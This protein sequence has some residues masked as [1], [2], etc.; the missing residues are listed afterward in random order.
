LHLAPL[1]LQLGD[2]LHGLLQC[3]GV[4]GLWGM[5]GSEGWHTGEE[6]SAPP[7]PDI[8]RQLTGLELLEIKLFRVSKP[9]LMLKRLFCSA[10]M[11]FI[12][13]FC[14]GINGSLGCWPSLGHLTLYHFTAR[15]MLSS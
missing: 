1:L 15:T 11:C 7:D 3:D 2:V 4:A 12:C 10:E 13:R 6:H 8:L 14:W 9:I 5:G